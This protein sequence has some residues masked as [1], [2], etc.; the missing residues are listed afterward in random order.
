[1]RYLCAFIMV[2]AALLFGI[3]VFA[4]A[5]WY[6]EGHGLHPAIAAAVGLFCCVAAGFAAGAIHD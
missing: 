6:F 1:M 4:G 3:V 2:A 5:A